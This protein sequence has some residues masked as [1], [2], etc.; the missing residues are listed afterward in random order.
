VTTLSTPYG[1]A[2]P[3]TAPGEI[4]SE[5]AETSTKKRKDVEV[6]ERKGGAPARVNRQDSWSDVKELE[7]GDIMDTT[8]PQNRAKFGVF[9]A[10]T[11]DPWIDEWEETNDPWIHDWAEKKNE[12]K[13]D[14]A[15]SVAFTNDIG[16]G[17]TELAKEAHEESPATGRID[18]SPHTDPETAKAAR[19]FHPNHV[20]KRCACECML[21]CHCC[22]CCGCCGVSK[23]VKAR[24]ASERLLLSRD[25]REFPGLSSTPL[26]SLSEAPNPARQAPKPA[27]DAPMSTLLSP[28]PSQ[29]APIVTPLK[30]ATP[31]AKS[32]K[33]VA[34][35]PPAEAPKTMH[36]PPPPAPPAPARAV[37]PPPPKK[38]KK[39]GCTIM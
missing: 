11:S 19:L 29:A 20:S 32:S 26:N 38:K 12:E 1:V 21:C 14:L 33:Q 3:G 8:E 23:E 28:K 34:R 37:A 27:S 4:V 18:P 22:C 39:K 10:A 31:T 25:D 6:S 17:I 16:G 24:K 5:P 35:K 13:A 15:P 9:E 2:N 7:V 30:Q 36:V